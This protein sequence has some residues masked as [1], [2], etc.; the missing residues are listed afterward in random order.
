MLGKDLSQEDSVPVKSSSSADKDQ[1][2]GDSVSINWEDLKVDFNNQFAFNLNFTFDMVSDYVMR[3]QL[4]DA[5][6]PRYD[7]PADFVNKP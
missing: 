6:K 3:L 2:V 4:T 5:D 7:V 1:K